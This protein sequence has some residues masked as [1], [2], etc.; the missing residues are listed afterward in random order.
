MTINKKQLINNQI[1]ASEVRLIDQEGK[2]L[3]VLKIEVA[4][5]IA[6]D[7]GLDLVEIAPEAEPVVCKILDF[8]KFHFE[9]EKREKENR[10]K[11]PVV[12]T[13]EIQLSCKIAAGDFLTKL[14]RAKDFLSEGNKV[15]VLIKFMGR[16]IAR[17]E[18]GTEL[19]GR[20]IEGCGELCTVEKQPLLDG[21]NMIAILAPLK[22]AVKKQEPVSEDSSAQA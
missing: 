19:V 8:G 6:A 16:E 7:A 17:P 22:K 5:R 3:G 20:F 10:R 1:K 14:N 13:K 11:A 18:R 12:V 4:R 2:Q 15:K 9:K 21:R